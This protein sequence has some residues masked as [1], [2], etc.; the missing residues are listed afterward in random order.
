MITLQELCRI[1]EIDIRSYSGRGMYGKT[2]LGITA[3]RVN[4]AFA[5]LLTACDNVGTDDLPDVIAMLAEALRGAQ[6]D[7]MGRD[8]ILYFPDVPWDETDDKEESDEAEED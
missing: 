4:D 1:A 6:T 5:D 7:S 3:H 2:C 8:M